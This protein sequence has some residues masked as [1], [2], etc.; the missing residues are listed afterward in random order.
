M[1]RKV[2]IKQAQRHEIDWVN[3]KYGEVDFVNSTYDNEFIVIANVEDENAGLGRLVKIDD[4][5]IE[6]GGIYTFSNFRGLGVA[7]HIVSGLIDKNPFEQS[8]IWCLPFENLL[9]F[10][11]RFGFEMYQNGTIPESIEKKLKWCNTNDM[12]DKKVMLLCKNS[13]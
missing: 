10:Y 7:A 3:A 1:E 11:T 4:T 6:L 13:I 2:T 9:N 8:T 12:Y 5:N